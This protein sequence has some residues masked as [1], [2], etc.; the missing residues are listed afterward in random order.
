VLQPFKSEDGT[1]RI[2]GDKYLFIG[3]NTYIPRVE[4]KVI[5]EIKATTIKANEALHLK[6]LRPL[7]DSEGVKRR[8]GES[9]M[10]TKK[11][12][13]LPQAD[14]T[15][16][17]VVQAYILKEDNAIK[18]KATKDFKDAYGVERKAGEEWL[19]TKAITDTHFLNTKE[20]YLST[21]RIISL[22]SRQYCYIKNPIVNGKRQWGKVE[23]RKGE[24]EF[25]L[26]PGETLV[27]GKCQEVY[28]LSEDQGLLL[29]AKNDFKEYKAGEL[30][31]IKGP[32]EFIPPIEVKV[33]E[34]RMR[35]PLDKN[36]GI[37]V[38]D[39]KSGE[40]KLISG[41]TYMLEAHE[42]LWEKQLQLYTE[43]LLQCGQERMAIADLKREAAKPRDKTKAVSFKVTKGKAVQIYDFKMK[44]SRVVFG[45]EQVMLQP[46]EVI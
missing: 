46:Y 36:E 28:V 11:G 13:Y 37:Y 33:I 45:P 25:F 9:W 20:R 26:Q 8:P 7:T 38:R 27:D 32:C 39:L 3:P 19:I 18:I 14:E 31:M 5:N 15:I 40:V 6:A 34:K 12:N 30:W 44:V 1:D 41:Q 35:Y 42:I 29:Q 23:L 21:Q 2:V 22:S 4:E 17:Q 16:L 24:R 43:R 10:Y